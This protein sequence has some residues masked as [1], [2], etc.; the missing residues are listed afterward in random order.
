M[1]LKNLCTAKDTIIWQKSRSA[2]WGKLFTNYTSHSGLGCTIYGEL[3]KNN[4]KK[5]NNPTL[6]WH[7]KL[8]R[9]FSKDGH[10]LQS[11]TTL[12]FHLI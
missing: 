11:Q 4:I 7:M 2:E 12:R 10:N 9:K 8:N 1:K 6:K 3:N 5:T